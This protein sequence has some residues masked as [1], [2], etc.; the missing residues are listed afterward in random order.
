[1]VLEFSP[2]DRPHQSDRIG[3]SASSGQAVKKIRYP[4]GRAITVGETV[5]DEQHL[6]LGRNLT[7]SENP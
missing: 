6:Q 2:A 5:A 3:L 4:G 7:G 1:M